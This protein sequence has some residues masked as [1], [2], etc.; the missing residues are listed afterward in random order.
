MPITS[1]EGMAETSNTLLQ[2]CSLKSFFSIQFSFQIPILLSSG[3]FCLES[4]FV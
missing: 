2:K 3:N 4:S 1:I